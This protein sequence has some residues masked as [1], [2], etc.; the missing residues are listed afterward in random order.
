MNL[1]YL[2]TS[3][4]VS[5]PSN[6]TVATERPF[7]IAFPV[8]IVSICIV[9]GF[10]GNNLVLYVYKTR[11]NKST[12][13]IF[14]LCLALFD[15]VECGIG[16]PFMI[17]NQFSV[18]SNAA[19]KG[20]TFVQYFVS[21]GSDLMLVT[22]AFERYRRVCKPSCRQISPATGK[23]LAFVIATIS[24][25]L[26]WPALLLYEYDTF[27]L[28]NFSEGTCHIYTELLSG[29][30]YPVVYYAILA[31]TWLIGY[32][33]V[34]TFYIMIWRQM[35]IQ[36]DISRR[37]RTLSVKMSKKSETGH[38]KTQ[39]SFAKANHGARWDVE[40]I[41]VQV[42]YEDSKNHQLPGTK[43][44]GN[45]LEQSRLTECEPSLELTKNISRD[46]LRTERKQTQS[47]RQSDW[48]RLRKITK[49]MFV[50]AL[51]NMVSYIP[52]IAI[53]ILTFSYPNRVYTA[54]EEVLYFQ[55]L[56]RSFMINSV[57]NPIIY[58]LM[59]QNFRLECKKLKSRW[60]QRIKL[61]QFPFMRNK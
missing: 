59:D 44:S 10:T 47:S 28:D 36:Y 37:R 29:S 21:I 8:V 22:I 42:T 2:P 9:V 27:V 15:C 31:I 16:M 49:I 52:H 20:F 38:H 61:I 48:D 46:F 1:S 5:V 54:V 43:S 40:I 12:Y 26:S 6:E 58:G 25:S 51:V 11:W 55:I 19:C 32:N 30:I 45:K 41:E 39:D 57:V 7:L 17:A 56:S 13:C 23:L 50:I 60:Q 34:T 35:K 53:S 3:S 33:L 4:P 14:I 24:L 18:S